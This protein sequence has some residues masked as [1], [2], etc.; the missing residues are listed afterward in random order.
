MKIRLLLIAAMLVFASCLADCT[1]P[2]KQHHSE[3]VIARSATGFGNLYY[4]QQYA[5]AIGMATPESRPWI[6][7]AASALTGDDLSVINAETKAS[8]AEAGAVELTSDTTATVRLTVSQ[9]FVID[10]IGQPG[11]FVDKQEVMLQLVKR[12]DDWLVSL[13]HRL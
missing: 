5:E 8:L 9:V 11:H 13:A 1:G 7:F 4:N 3:E 12:G 2:A 10:S 6:V